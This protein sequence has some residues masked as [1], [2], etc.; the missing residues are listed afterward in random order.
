MPTCPR[1]LVKCG[2]PWSC[3][4][5][6][7][8]GTTKSRPKKELAAADCNTQTN[9]NYCA[10]MNLNIALNHLLRTKDGKVVYFCFKSSELLINIS[11]LSD[12]FM[13]TFLF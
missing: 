9:G 1:H 8:R 13:N 7:Y 10:H 4:S 12:K 11:Q 5:T 2:I 3:S 6:K